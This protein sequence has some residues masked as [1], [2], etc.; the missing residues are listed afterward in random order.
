MS[1]LQNLYET[2]ENNFDMVG[3]FEKNSEG[4]EF[5]LLPL[6][7]TNLIAHIEIVVNEQGEFVWADVVKKEDSYTVSPCTEDSQSRTRKATPHPLH[8][9]IKYVAGDFVD[10][11]GEEKF[12]EANELYLNN[13]KEMILHPNCHPKIK[14]I[15]QYIK[16]KTIIKDLYE[17]GK[18]K[19]DDNN[20][21]IKKWSK[22]GDKPELYKVAS[23]IS[24]AVVRF[25]VHL[26]GEMTDKVWKDKDV[27]DSYIEYYSSRLDGEDLCYVTLIE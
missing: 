12:K 24:K 1:W 16:K 8:D 4:E 3:R 10:Y 21:L 18:I 14:S 15:Y 6:Y 13:F 23:D 26:E 27:F 7:H 22:N 25:D 19:I 20:Q 17:H 9:G 2:Y 5:T 11:G